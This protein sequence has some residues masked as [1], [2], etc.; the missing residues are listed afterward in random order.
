MDGGADREADRAD[1]EADRDADD[2]PNCYAPTCN[3]H[4]I[5]N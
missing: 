3:S 2:L 5:A 1:Q 4:L